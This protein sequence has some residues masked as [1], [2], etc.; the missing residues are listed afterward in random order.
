MEI[1]L[2]PTRGAVQWDPTLSVA[3]K[4]LLSGFL[5]RDPNNRLGSGPTGLNGDFNVVYMK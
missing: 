5:E 3:A 1:F 2:L 4:E